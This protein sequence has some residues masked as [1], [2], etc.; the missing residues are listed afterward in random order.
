MDFDVFISYSHEDKAAAD[1]ACATLEQHGIRCWIAPRDIIPGMD[2]GEAIIDAIEHANLMVLIFSGHAN[3]SPQ[4]KREVERAV[5]K[6]VPIIPVRIEDTA[7]S[8]SLEYFISTPHWLD[9]FTPPLEERL[10]QL[11]TAAKALLGT[12]LAGAEVP[13][14]A[15]LLSEKSSPRGLN[16]AIATINEARRAVWAIGFAIGASVVAGVCAALLAMAGHV[17]AASVI[18]GVTAAGLILLLAT[19]FFVTDKNPKI[20]TSA[21]ALAWSVSSLLIVF[22][23]LAAT[24][25]GLRWPTTM[26][27]MLGIEDGV[28]CARPS[29]LLKAFSCGAPADGSYVIANIRLDDADFGL[30]VREGPNIQTIGRPVPPNGTGVA[31][32]APCDVEVPDAWCQV[33]CKRLSLSGW[34]R[35]RYLRPR[36]EALYMVSGAMPIDDDGLAVRTGPHETCHQIGAIPPQARD[37]IQHWCQRSPLDI[38]S[39]CRITYGGISGWISDGFLEHQN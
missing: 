3:E 26:A 10:K 17:Q 7:P 15:N 22:F 8:K 2:W 34:S 19:C 36:S 1:A 21:K 29:E 35:A 16:G 23:A 6:G 14:M 32:T 5:N 4:I 20:R 28:I 33:E 24:G 27:S 11:A 30:M 39:W 38:T 31:V 12:I 13:A 18:A 37:V 9:A 25:I